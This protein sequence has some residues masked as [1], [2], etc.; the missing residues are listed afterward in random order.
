MRKEG[1]PVMNVGLSLLILIFIT[2]SLLTFSVLSLENAVADRRLSEK[3]ADHTTA[4]YEA[5]N[6]IQ[7][8]LAEHLDNAGAEGLKAGTEILFEEPVSD[9]QTLVVSVILTE[10][11]GQGNAAVGASD[12]KVTRWQLQPSDAW[13]ADRSLDVY[14]G[15]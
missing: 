13:E 7:E 1:I 5:A 6:R 8:Q 10:A 14:Q 3:A 12:Y 9:G 15:E 11:D 4:Y 2:L